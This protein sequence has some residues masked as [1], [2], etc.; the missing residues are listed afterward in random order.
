MH[1]VKRLE[2]VSDSVELAKIVSA[3]EKAGVSS[4]SV[5]RNVAGRLPGGMNSDDM[6]VTTLDSVYLL[7]FCLPDQVKPL[8]E[9]IRPVLNKFGGAC[10]VSDAME[11]KS[12]RCVASL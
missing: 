11:V 12:M 8:V 4:Y 6:A 3:L 1:A 2:I 10:Y 7:A 9:T 5:V